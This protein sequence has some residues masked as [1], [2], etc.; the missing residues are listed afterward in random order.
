M[1]DFKG[2]HARI[3]IFRYVG[4]DTYCAYAFTY[5]YIYTYIYY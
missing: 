3:D 5:I 2:N 1:K 4:T